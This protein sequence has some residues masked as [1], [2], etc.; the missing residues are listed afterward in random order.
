MEGNKQSDQQTKQILYKK[1]LVTDVSMSQ[2]V[3][4]NLPQPHR[5]HPTLQNTHTTVAFEGDVVFLFYVVVF[6]RRGGGSFVLFVHSILL[7]NPEKDGVSVGRFH[8]IT[9]SY[10]FDVMECIGQSFYTAISLARILPPHLS[11]NFDF[12]ET[13]KQLTRCNFTMRHSII[14]SRTCRGNRVYI[15]VRQRGYLYL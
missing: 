2:Y 12:R 1:N 7:L 5:P 8:V 6:Q 15:T 3:C 11:R 14:F 4:G 10:L 9:T 13:V